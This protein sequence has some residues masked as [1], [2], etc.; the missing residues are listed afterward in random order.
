ML[1]VR[2]RKSE[3]RLARLRFK[4]HPGVQNYVA[5]RAYKK[6]FFACHIKCVQAD[7]GVRMHVRYLHVLLPA[8]A[9]QYSRSTTIKPQAVVVSQA[10]RR[11]YIFFDQHRSNPLWMSNG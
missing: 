4:L 5:L 11:T 9:R 10:Q 2:N 6:Y 8:S 1:T 3:T 7:F